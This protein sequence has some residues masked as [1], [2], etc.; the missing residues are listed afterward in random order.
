MPVT[1]LMGLQ[2]GD[3]GKGKIVDALAKDVDLV[4]RAQGGAN[5]GHTVKVGGDTF[6]LHL[7]PSG[8]LY[9][10]VVGVIGHGVVVDPL[11]LV[12]EIRALERHD[13]NL[14]GRLWVSARAHLVLPSHKALDKAHESRRGA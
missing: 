11:T 14:D 9:S 13:Q 8:I 10:H 5:A 1:A 2:W 4:V 12:E 7:I 6:V 3:E